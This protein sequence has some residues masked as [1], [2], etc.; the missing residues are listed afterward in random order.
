MKK[1]TTVYKFSEL[2][3]EAKAKAIA[4]HREFISND[5]EWYNQALI[6]IDAIAADIGITID[7]DY[8]DGFHIYFSMDENEL[9]FSGTFNQSTVSLNPNYPETFNLVDYILRN[10]H[11]KN[12]TATINSN[13][14]ED[15]SKPSNITRNGVMAV[16]NGFKDMALATLKKEYDYLTSEKEIIQNIEVND[17]DFLE[18]GTVFYS[19]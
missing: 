19:R 6:T 13:E 3:P 10:P 16:I 4:N 15:I 5:A 17:Y 7:S 12:V 11:L 8:H 9:I 18:N 1:V 2:S 14:I